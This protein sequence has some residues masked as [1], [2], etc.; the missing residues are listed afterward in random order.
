[1]IK[2]A[3][4]LD[5]P[6]ETHQT[7]TT[8]QIG[9]RNMVI[10]YVLWFFLGQLGL[11]RFYLG[12]TGSAIVQLILGLVGYMTFAIFGLGLL[13]LIPLWIWLFIDIFLIPGMSSGGPLMSTTTTTTILTAA[14]ETTSTTLEGPSDP[15]GNAES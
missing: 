5:N 14:T 6:R 11:H 9:S 3:L 7:T 4:S 13:F 10:A 2:G 12:R 15:P 8:V 1:M